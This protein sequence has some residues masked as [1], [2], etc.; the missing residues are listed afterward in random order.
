MYTAASNYHV[1]AIDYRGFGSSTGSPT[2]DGLI[3][4]ASAALH[5]ALDTVGLPPSRIAILGHS[6]GSAVAAAVSERFAR[7]HGIDFAGVVL[8]SGFSSLPNMLSGYAIAGWVPIFWPVR[9]HPRLLRFV[10]GFIVD[11]WETAKRLRNIVGITQTCNATAGNKDSKN[12]KT[13]SPQRHL[14]LSL[15]HAADDWD[16][17]CEE[18]DK[19]FA[20][21]VE[22]LLP[23]KDGER[24]AV[25]DF[26]ALKESHTEHIGKNA[27]VTEWKDGGVFIRQERFPHGGKLCSR[28]ETAHHRKR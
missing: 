13:S 19:I 3:L 24:I 27:F 15:I 8:V 7:V 22:P 6:L 26:K 28:A 25:E 12:S 17:P 11:H 23:K 21:A 18:D 10:L 9:S 4:D 14:R 16:I 20:T 2:E 1:L 5:F